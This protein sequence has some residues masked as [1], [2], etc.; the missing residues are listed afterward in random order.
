MYKIK[1]FLKKII[2][3]FTNY[4]LVHFI[5]S[6]KEISLSFIEAESALEK[7]SPDPKTS[8]LWNVPPFKNTYDLTVIIPVYK[9]EKYL[10]RCIESVLHQKTAYSY[11]VLVVNDCSPDNSKKILEKYKDNE[12]I[13]IIN[14]TVNSG[15]SAARNTALKEVESRYVTFLDSDDFLTENAV[16]DMLKFAYKYNADIVQGGYY[17]IEDK[18]G[19]VLGCN[20]YIECA[21]VSS[22]GAVSGMPWGKVYKARLFEKVCFPEKYWFED[23]IVTALL[24]HIANNIVTIGNMVY[25]YRK[26]YSGIT[27]SSKVNPKAID[28]YWVH[29]CVLEAR[30]QLGFT[31]DVKFYEHMLRMIILSYKRTKFAPENIKI[32]LFISF[33]EMLLTLRKENF[34]MNRKYKNLEKAI[35]NKDY[36]KFVFLCEWM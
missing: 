20:K 22:N 24:S 18:T 2:S 23:T 15:V 12:L 32:S 17:D 9:V 11:K 6:T 33:R 5:N 13:K 1:R 21:F 7:Y 26:N 35:I 10:E 30:E 19:K 8:A 31:T 25:Y 29:K 27:S 28:T 16:N 36:K 4:I 14:H 3:F 34:K